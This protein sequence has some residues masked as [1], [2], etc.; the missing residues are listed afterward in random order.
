MSS[1][2]VCLEL[3]TVNMLLFRVTFLAL[4]FGDLQSSS[5]VLLRGN[6][7]S[8]FHTEHVQRLATASFP[9]M[10]FSC[11]LLVDNYPPS[12]WFCRRWLPPIRVFRLWRNIVVLSMGHR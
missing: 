9:G 10:L 11:R 1:V 8:V 2:L 3:F 6:G 4:S 5:I 7:P 12:P